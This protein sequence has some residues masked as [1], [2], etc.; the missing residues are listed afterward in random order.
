MT[1]DLIFGSVCA[2]FLLGLTW[3][4][5]LGIVE[6]FDPGG[7]NYPDTLRAAQEELQT[8]DEKFSYLFYYSY[9]TLTTLGYG[10]ITPRTPFT[11]VLAT[12]EAFTGQLFLTILVA[13]LV[14]LRITQ[15][16]EES[17]SSNPSD[18]A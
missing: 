2:Y 8:A 10:D 4:F 17:D 5:G 3:A 11:Q 9:I 6:W 12:L 1:M 7:F 14:S 13:H 15:R 16:F 18:S